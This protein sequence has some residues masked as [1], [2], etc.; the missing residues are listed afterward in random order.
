MLLRLLLITL[1]CVKYYLHD[2]Q[3][4]QSKLNFN[5]SETTITAV[6]QI[7]LMAGFKRLPAPGHSF[8][9]WLRNI[10]LK[11]DKT[12]FLY[13]GIPKQNQSAQFAVL[14]IPVGNKNLQQCADAVIRLRASYLFDEKR[15]DEIVFKDNL[16][17][18]Y[19]YGTI[20]DDRH[21]QQYLENVFAYC[22][23]LSLEKQL[24]KVNDI[25]EIVAGDVFIKG[26]SPGHAVIVMDVAINDAGKKIYLLAQSYMPAQDIH[27]LVNPIYPSVSPW[28]YVNDDKEI[29]TPEWIFARSQLKQW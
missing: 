15:F 13:N 28:Y 9:S 16:G 11:K 10:K 29:V 12:V 18:A 24:K 17:K 22:G 6:S 25:N 8:T 4:L 14:D 21:F 19:V 7:P 5:P 3:C 26:G 27:I 23:T 20:K 2:T 1:L